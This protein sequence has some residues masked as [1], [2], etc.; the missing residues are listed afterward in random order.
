MIFQP[1]SFHI[2]FICN[3]ILLTYM[4]LSINASS[5]APRNPVGKRCTL[6]PLTPGTYAAPLR[7]MAHTAPRSS[8]GKLRTRLRVTLG[9]FAALLRYLASTSR[10]NHGADWTYGDGK[11][12]AILRF[13]WKSWGNA[14]VPWSCSYFFYSMALVYV[15]IM[16]GVHVVG[17][18]LSFIQRSS[19]N[20]WLF[21]YE[22]S[23]VKGIMDI[24]ISEKCNTDGAYTPIYS[25]GWWLPPPPPPRNNA[26]AWKQ[27][28]SSSIIFIFFI[29]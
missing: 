3:I 14:S 20:L 12:C 7:S 4:Y 25:L 11:I 27:Y 28:G 5:G 17:A 16:H 13:L 2:S 1:F 6:L 10:S 18:M 26:S 21:G 15:C 22:V 8:M 29:G 9:T 24:S 19:E 23:I